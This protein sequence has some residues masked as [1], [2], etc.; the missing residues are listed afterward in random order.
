MVR[1]RMSKWEVALGAPDRVIIPCPMHDSHLCQRDV[2]MTII[3][4]GSEKM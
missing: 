2:K 1:C 3:Y 4:H